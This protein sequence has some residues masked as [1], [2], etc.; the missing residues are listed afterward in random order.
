MCAAQNE[1]WGDILILGTLLEKWC[2]YWAESVSRSRKKL[3]DDRVKKSKISMAWGL[4]QKFLI[5]CHDGF[6][7]YLKI[8]SSD[9]H[10]SNIWVVS[11]LVMTND[12]I[13]M[14]SWPMVLEEFVS[15]F[16]FFENQDFWNFMGG[17]ARYVQSKINSG[18]ILWFLGHFWKNDVY[19][20]QSPYLAQERSYE[21]I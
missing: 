9:M 3:W 10:D 6:W 21:T 5:W 17:C 4:P 7:T 13:V 8:H 11:H 18:V 15:T 2:I 20:C 1:I 12:P 19:I 16:R 14:L